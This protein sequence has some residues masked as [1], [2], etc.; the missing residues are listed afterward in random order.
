[1]LLWLVF[2]ALTVIALLGAALPLLRGARNQSQRA[3]YDLQV[4]R[5]QLD[6]LTERSRSRGDY[7]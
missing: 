1:M 3:E 5:H 4:Y 2:A 6:E 7:T